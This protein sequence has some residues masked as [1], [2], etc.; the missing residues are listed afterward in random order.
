MTYVGVGMGGEGVRARRRTS[1][2]R[3]V[4]T[5]VPLIN[6]ASSSAHTHTPLA[7]A[8]ANK[9][10][11]AF[12]YRI[13]ISLCMGSTTWRG[14]LAVSQRCQGYHDCSLFVCVIERSKQDI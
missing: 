12:L 9:C 5:G 6:T 7:L 1:P 14:G 13:N 10:V 8:P 2:L 3:N 4:C 11:R